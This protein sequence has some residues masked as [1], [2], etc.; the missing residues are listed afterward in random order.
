GGRIGGRRRIGA[1]HGHGG[2]GARHA[3]RGDMRVVASDEASAFVLEHG[4]RLWVRLR[5]TRCCRSLLTYL[6]AS[7]NAPAGTFRR[8]AGADGGVEV[9]MQEGL[10]PPPPRPHGTLRPLAGPR[11]AAC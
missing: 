1:A 7:T 3:G 2:R 9:D 10:A 6:D 11:G 8:V 5:S 4:G